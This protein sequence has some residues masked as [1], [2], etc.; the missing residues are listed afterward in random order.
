MHD[1]LKINSHSSLFTLH[2]LPSSASHLIGRA[3]FFIAS[4]S[5]I[6][7]CTVAIQAQ[8]ENARRPPSVSPS[9]ALTRTTVRRETRRLGYGSA[10]TVLGA[11]IGSITIEAWPR[12]EVEI[13]AS[14]EVRAD[15]EEDLARLA[16]VTNFA[17]DAEANHLRIITTGTHDRR[18][19]RRAA[20]DFPRRLLNAPWKIDYRIR[21]PAQIDLEIYGGRGATAVQ[22][23]EGAAMI[24][25]SEGDLNL[26]LTGG[27]VNA[28]VGRGVVRF[29]AA[30]R[31]WRGQG[32]EIR[33]AA[34]DLTVEIPANFNADIMA[35]IAQTG[36]IE[37]SYSS[38]APR[39]ENAPLQPNERTL[40]GRAGSGGAR[41]T[42]TV[43]AGT[44]RIRQANNQ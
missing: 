18:F 28:T 41:L 38:L 27:S 26:T 19:M 31:S 8:G 36:R 14:I 21:V 17:L 13:E 39:D 42:F 1:E 4:I 40:A 15:T 7:I 37:N 43:G 30:S 33:L 3:L 10:L 20:R 35:S 2:T 32:A 16:S 22:G 34:G 12:S 11:P 24:N 29:V 25:V 5:L 44:L 23:T 6:V 9:P